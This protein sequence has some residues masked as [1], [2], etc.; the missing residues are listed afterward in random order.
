[1]QGRQS[2]AGLMLAGGAYRGTIIMAITREQVEAVF[3]K[4]V[5]AAVEKA[6]ALGIAATWNTD[7]HR[8]FTAD[9]IAEC[10]KGEV[11]PAEIEQALLLCSN[12]SAARQKLETR[13]AQAGSKHFPKQSRKSPAE[14]VDELIT[15]LAGKK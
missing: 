10:V 9:V 13:S 8:A 6:E 12:E 14:G 3:M 15:F 11:E 7:K 2:R 4:H 5:V 1:M